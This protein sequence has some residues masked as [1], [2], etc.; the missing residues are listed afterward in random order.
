M[1]LLTKNKKF[2]FLFKIL[3]KIKISKKFKIKSNKK[4]KF[5]FNKRKF[6]VNF[7]FSIKIKGGKKVKTVLL[8]VSQ[9]DVMLTHYLKKKLKLALLLYRRYRSFINAGLHSE[10][11]LNSILHR[12]VRRLRS[13]AESV[14][15]A[16]SSS[17][18]ATGPFNE[19]Q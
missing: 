16:S 18:V 14:C 10:P 6:V 12:A 2:W 4:L 19:I 15:R 13:Y 11:H 1:Q 8:V 5:F 7:L 9:I 3:W 17:L